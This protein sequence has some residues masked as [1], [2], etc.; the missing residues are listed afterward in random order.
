MTTDN[1]QAQA[2]A[3]PQTTSVY[4]STP[5]AR[6]SFWDVGYEMKFDEGT[7]ELCCHLQFY[8]EKGAINIIAQ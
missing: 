7:S 2:F 6:K 8:C 4:S 1:L 5:Q 3:C